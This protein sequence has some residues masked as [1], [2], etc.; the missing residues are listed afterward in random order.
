AY[1][2][3]A[4]DRSM[5]T[6]PRCGRSFASRNQ[7]HACTAVTVEE[8][9]KGKSDAATPIYRAFEEA[10]LLQG[11]SR[12]HATKT[13]IAFINRMTFASATLG[14]G[15]VDATLILPE[16]V[17][18]PRFDRIDLYGAVTYAQ[19]IR[20]ASAEAVDAELG[21][22]LREAYHRGLQDDMTPMPVTVPAV[23]RVT[24]DRWRCVFRGRVDVSGRVDLPGYLLGSLGPPPLPRIRV[25]IGRRSWVAEIGSGAVSLAGADAGEADVTTRLVS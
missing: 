4:V 8:H 15:H 19:R 25:R 5:W 18:H 10:M 7:T 6:C 22:W 11:E 17:D 14:S 21:G 9:L 13:R 16:W 2:R 23:A 1:P 24:A 3:S 20:L 12:V